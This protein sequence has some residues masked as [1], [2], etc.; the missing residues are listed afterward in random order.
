MT[1]LRGALHHYGNPV[2]GWLITTG[3]VLSGAKEEAHSS[4]ASPMVLT[5]RTELA[6]LF[7]AHGIGVRTQRIEVP[8]LDVALFDGLSG[9]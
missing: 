3:Q 1:E 5:G 6:D 2:M 8:V 4:G 7:L 9:R